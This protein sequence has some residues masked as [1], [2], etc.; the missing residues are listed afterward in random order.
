MARGIQRI[1]DVEELNGAERARE[2]WALTA[3]EVEVLAHIAAGLSN[4]DIAQRL[5]A[6]ERTVEIHVSALLRKAHADT[7]SQLVIDLWHL[8]ERP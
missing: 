7:R 8:A 3:R 4:R 1:T 6:S 5:A 2:R